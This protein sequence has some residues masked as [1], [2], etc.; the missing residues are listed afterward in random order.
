MAFLTTIKVQQLRWDLSQQPNLSSIAHHID[1]AE[2]LRP[3]VSRRL[4][5]PLACQES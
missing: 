5:A 4:S 3:A 2:T 1:V